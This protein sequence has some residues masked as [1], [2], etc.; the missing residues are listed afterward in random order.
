MKPKT[1][2]V[3]EEEYPPECTD[4]KH[5]DFARS[6]LFKV[7]YNICLIGYTKGEENLCKKFEK[8][9]LFKVRLIPLK[10]A[11]KHAIKI[12]RRHH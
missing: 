10:D 9:K 4:C 7:N 6:D 3:Y 1:V 12:F 2:V 8:R 11:V 5:F